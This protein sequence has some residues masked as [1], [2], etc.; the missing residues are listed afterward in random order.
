[1]KT[2]RHIQLVLV[3]V[4]ATISVSLILV[5]P[6]T[7]AQSTAKPQQPTTQQAPPPQPAPAGS[8]PASAPPKKP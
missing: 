4:L 2:S 3:A 8:P 5:S 1:M 6:R 7:G